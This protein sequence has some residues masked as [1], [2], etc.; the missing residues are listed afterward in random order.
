[1]TTPDLTRSLI[2]PDVKEPLV[3]RINGVSV[4]GTKD[5]SGN[6]QSVHA[7][8]TDN[9][10]YSIKNGR[11]TQIQSATETLTFNYNDTDKRFMVTVVTGNSSYEIPASYGTP[12]ITFPNPVF[13]LPDDRDIP[14]PFTGIALSLQDK[15]TSRSINDATLQINYSDEQLGNRSN[16]MIN[17]GGGHYYASLPVNDTT[18]DAYFS[19]SNLLKTIPQQSDALIDLTRSYPMADICSQIPRSVTG[20]CSLI[21]NDMTKQIPESLTVASKWTAQIPMQPKSLGRLHDFQVVIAI[22][23]EQMVIAVLDSSNQI[24]SRALTSRVNSEY[25]INPNVLTGF[26]LRAG[27]SRGKCN[28]E[29]VAG[30]DTPDDR[31]IDIGKANTIIKF[32]YETYSIK[33]QMDVYYRNQQVF[34]TSC[35]GTEGELSTDIVLNG[36]ES[37]VRV[38][39]IPDCAG[40]MDTAWYYTIECSFDEVICRDDS[41]SCG[42]QRSLS[43]QTKNPTSNGCGPARGVVTWFSKPIG[44]KWKLTPSCNDHDICY[45]ECNNNKATCD[46]AFI[47]SMLA[48]CH[49]NWINATDIQACENRANIFYRA[50]DFLGGGPFEDAQQEDCTCPTK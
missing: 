21:A 39:V 3:I 36:N 14:D 41:C 12:N 26:T 8:Q 31:V 9:A 40:E 2:V 16:V 45:G 30:N 50:V 38:N 10:I 27:G 15:V 43:T 20:F 6:V 34:S 24:S 35:V 46:Q 47:V 5:Y 4:F 28:E 32:R 25:R 49:L 42:V 1:M 48:S 29:T 17:L 33:D 44:D 22:P 23:G 13:T 11:I 37:S 7:I 19:A 18:I